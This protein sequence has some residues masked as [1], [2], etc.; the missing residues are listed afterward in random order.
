M[1]IGANLLTN[2]CAYL[3]DEAGDY[4]VASETFTEV[5][6]S[7]NGPLLTRDCHIL[8]RATGERVVAA[9][10][11]RDLFAHSRAQ[12]LATPKASPVRR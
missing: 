10:N 11:D 5:R 8:A 9:S 7:S 4:V 2:D 1:P 12:P 6:V 3:T